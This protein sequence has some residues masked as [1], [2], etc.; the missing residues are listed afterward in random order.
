MIP[1]RVEDITRVYTSTTGF[2]KKDTRTVTAL[3]RVSIKVSEGEIFGLLGQN[4]AGK[5]TLVKIMATLL[6][7]TSGRAEILGRDAGKDA[8]WIRRKIGILFGGDRG[9][10]WRLSGLDNM[11]Y[12]ADLHRMDPVLAETRI[13]KLLELVGL[14]EV[15]RQK[16]QVYSRGMKQRLHLARAL[17]HD[18]TVL[19]LDEPTIGVDPVGSKEIRRIVLELARESKTIFLTTHNTAEAEELCN[20]IAILKEGEVIAMDTP[21]G[22]RKQ[23]R[24]LTEIEIEAKGCEISVAEAIREV[25]GVEKVTITSD[26]QSLMQFRIFFRGND[27]GWGLYSCADRIA[28]LIG[29]ERVGKMVI[30]NPSLEDAYIQM[31]GGRVIDD[32]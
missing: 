24:G 30:K 9:L 19:F 32:F 22:L 25:R 16:V 14:T 28:H 11:R 31:V 26:E 4:G 5:T 2:F 8:A 1:V 10:Y 18:P 13:W 27:D 17:L 7:P 29:I 23:V 20:R 6:K 15:A 3:K 12:F 21:A